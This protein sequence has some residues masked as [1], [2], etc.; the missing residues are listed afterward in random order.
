MADLMQIK[1]GQGTKALFDGELGYK[2]DEEALYIGTS[3][4]VNKRLCG[5]GDDARLRA[6]GVAIAELEQ[7]KLTASQINAMESVPQDAVLTDVIGAFNSLIS[8]LKEKGI[9]AKEE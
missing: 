9:M 3:G 6:A 2:E 4:G 5:V 1:R 8:D 7:N